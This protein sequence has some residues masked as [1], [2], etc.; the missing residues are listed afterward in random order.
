MRRGGGRPNR[1]GAGR[2]VAGACVSREVY[3]RIRRESR[4]SGRVFS[5]ELRDLIDLGLRARELAN[6]MVGEGR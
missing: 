2:K 1:L 4:K 6:D 3:E 5:E